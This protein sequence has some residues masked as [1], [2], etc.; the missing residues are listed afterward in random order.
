[1]TYYHSRVGRC[2]GSIQHTLFCCLSTLLRPGPHDNVRE[3]TLSFFL[4]WFFCHFVRLEFLQC[5][6]MTNWLGLASHVKPS[7]S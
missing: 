1:M 3:A 7:S 5:V 4:F 6:I 2:L